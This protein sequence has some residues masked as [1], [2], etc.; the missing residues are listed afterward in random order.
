RTSDVRRDLSCGKHQG[1]STK[2]QANTWSLFGPWCLV[3]GAFHMRGPFERLK[4]DLRRL[5]ECPVC[6]RRERTAGTVTFRHCP[7]QMNK[8]D[9][10][11]IVMK[12]VEDGVQ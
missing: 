11:L 9:G 3:L 12:F 6:N 8:A 2:D 4:Y 1:P 10:K 5:W 7:C